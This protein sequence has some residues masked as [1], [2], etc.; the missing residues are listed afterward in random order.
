MAQTTRDASFEP[1]FIA[2]AHS[3]PLRHRRGNHGCRGRHW[4]R[5]CSRCGPCRV[6]ALS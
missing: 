5:R 2:A 4:T 3:N 1:V 6:V